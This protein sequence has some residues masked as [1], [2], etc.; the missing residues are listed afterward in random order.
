MNLEPFGS[1]CH[2][3][4]SPLQGL[5]GVGGGGLPCSDQIKHSQNRVKTEKS[6]FMTKPFLRPLTLKEDGS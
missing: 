6:K 5:V 4:L 3:T 2:M 1:K